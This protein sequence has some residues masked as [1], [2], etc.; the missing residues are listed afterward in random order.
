[1]TF[2]PK[3][4]RENYHIPHGSIFTVDATRIS[5]ET[6]GRPIPNTPM[7]G[8]LAKVT[9]VISKEN[10]IEDTKKNLSKKLSE[11]VVQKNLEA[12]NRAYE[13]VKSE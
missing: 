12:I 8:A 10:L 6:L 9:D 13:E 11:E 5:L 2:L 1:M 4:V 3:T 7:L